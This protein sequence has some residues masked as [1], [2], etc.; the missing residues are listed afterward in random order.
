M[1]KKKLNQNKQNNKKAMSDSAKINQSSNISNKDALR[2][3]IHEIHNYLRNNGAGYGMNALKVFNLIY[4]LKKI[5]EHNLIDKAE[6][7]R[8][9]CEFTH[10]L[11]IANTNDD[12]KLAD[13][14]RN[15][16]LDSI[17]ES[18]IRELLFYE[19]PHTF[20]GKSFS[21]LV[22]EINKITIIEETCN[23]L[24]SGKI[25]E[26]FIGR[27]ESAISELGAYFT[28]RHIVDYIYT[29]L[30]P[31]INDDGSIN[32]MIDMFGGSGGFTTGYVNY[33][34]DKYNNTIDWSKNINNIYHFD[35]NS[36]VVK[37]AGLEIFCLTGELPN[38]ESNIVYKNSFQDEYNNQKFINIVT[39]PP[40]GGDKTKKSSDCIKREKLKDYIKKDL[41][42]LTDEYKIESRKKQLAEI[43]KKDNEEKKEINKH[44]VTL[45]T[46]SSRI[47]KFA[48]KYKLKGN[49]KEAVSL[50]L[51]MELLDKDGTA[52][53]VLKEGVFFNSTYKNIRK[54]LMENFNVTEVIS[55]P[56]DQFENTST[57]TSILIF[58]NKEY[59]PDEIIKFSE[60]K[61]KKYEEDK[62]EEINNI[63]YITEN[64]G[65]ICY[66][67]EELI[68]EAK[69]D[70][71]INN[72][73]HS[74]NG[75]DYNKK[76]LKVSN[77]YELV[78]LGNIC[79]I[80]YGTRI[81]KINN[82]IGDIPVYGG[83]DI[84]FYTNKFNRDEN[85]LIVSRY[86]LSK[87]CVRLISNKFYLNDSGLSISTV[88]SK[89]QKY[90]NYYLL[91]EFMQN[92][93]YKK[94]TSGSIQNNLNMDLF[95]FINIPI[96][97]NKE[98]ITEW[99]EKISNPHDKK[100][101]A[102]K[103]FKE[104]E[105]EIKNKIK[106]I[107]E[108]E[109]CEEF[110]LGDIC[111]LNNKNIIKYDTSYGKEI[112][113]YKFH[114]GASNGQYYCDNYNIDKYTIIL[115]KTNG[116]GKCNIFLDKNIACA[117]QTFICQSLNSEIETQYLYYYL[118]DKKEQ[119]EIG[120][121]GACHK[122]L[123]SD[124]LKSFKIKIPKN[125]ELITNLE[126]MFKKVEELQNTIKES[127]IEYNQ[128][129]QELANDAII[130]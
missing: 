31:E 16:V 95:K 87:T 48:K 39:N 6:L 107:S 68:S 125:K 38:M 51:M 112:G 26:Y 128:Y 109:E 88:D 119:L 90:I 30:D 92:Y 72:K 23:V 81:T 54:C 93:I 3:K 57:K 122:N 70:E 15:K 40:Y 63:I 100:L 19:I 106:H 35:M 22:K 124:F 60:L 36:D 103:E 4:G 46:S 118:F 116:S 129:I 12:D 99:V 89:L 79:D 67:T 113:K 50:I 98:K 111:E 58:N 24:L 41:E 85:T 10:L 27:D 77:N 121:I 75:K 102:E 7:K 61:I 8:P 83:G 120:Y 91:S 20:G 127:E 47:I 71:I 5:E 108:N 84:T 25:Y 115:N 101:N 59:N 52:I 97:K 126:P 28:D 45:E 13:I 53:G 21:Y 73:I 78:K 82:I 130:E 66:I 76:E 44:K 94:C 117:K 9:E 123:S 1:N 18:N 80:K 42:N 33:I 96:P 29:K 64:K 14:I 34:N 11:N 69:K 55:V 2:D 49:D 37:S 110:K 86:A 65:D 104:L 32:N 105:E 62:F 43:I 17:A 114:T 74:L 56:Q